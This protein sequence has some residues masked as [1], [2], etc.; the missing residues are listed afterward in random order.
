[1]ALPLKSSMGC[2][3]SHKIFAAAGEKLNYKKIF[4]LLQVDISVAAV[5][6]HFFIISISFPKDNCFRNKLSVTDSSDSLFGVE[7][8]C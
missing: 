4:V 6:S 1:M 8:S 3:F 7:F 2:N 5:A